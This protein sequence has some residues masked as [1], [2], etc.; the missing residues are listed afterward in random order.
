MLLLK[1]INLLLLITLTIV[2]IN[3]YKTKDYCSKKLCTSA[4][5]TACGYKGSF[6]P[7]CPK[8]AEVVKMTDELKAFIVGKHN[9]V[10]KGVCKGNYKGLKKANRMIEMVK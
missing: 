3:T 9:E 10:R 4:K 2:P 1:L 5:H 8:N 7:K 6:G